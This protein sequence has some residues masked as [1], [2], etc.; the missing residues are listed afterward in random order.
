MAI[1]YPPFDSVRP[2]LAL[3][4]LFVDLLGLLVPSV[5]TLG[6]RRPLPGRLQGTKSTILCNAIKQMKMQGRRF[7]QMWSQ[8]DPLEL[9]WLPLGVQRD[10]SAPLGVPLAPLKVPLASPSA[11]KRSGD[12]WGGGPGPHFGHFG[13]QFGHTGHQIGHFGHPLFPNLGTFD[14]MLSLS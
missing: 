9:F 3:L 2:L 10:P 12:H 14:P 1:I 6:P 11:P 13:P 5:G 7:D 4:A 8:G